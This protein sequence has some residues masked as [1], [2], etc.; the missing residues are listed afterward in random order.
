MRT[1]VTYTAYCGYDGT[2]QKEI[3]LARV[4][5]LI[6]AIKSPNYSH[7]RTRFWCGQTMTTIYHRDKTSPS[8]VLSHDGADDAVVSF[9][10]RRYR[11]NSPLSPTEG[12]G[13]GFGGAR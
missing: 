4:K 2:Q 12:L 9:L 1:K 7:A 6:R 5:A 8:G 11:N 13:H 3:S 10:L